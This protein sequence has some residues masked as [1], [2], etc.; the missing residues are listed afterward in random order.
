MENKGCV[1][2]YHGNG[3]GKTTAAIGLC[4]RAAGA[5]LKVLIYQF[6]K[7]N[8]S[9]ERSVLKNIPGIT[10]VDGI[11]KAKFTFNMSS[12]EKQE[13]GAYCR[14]MFCSLVQT[15]VQGNYDV[16]LLD[17]VLHVLRKDM[18]SEEMLLDFLNERPD[19]MEVIL[20]G[21]NPSKKLVDCADYV[22]HI[23]KEKHPFDKKLGA[24]VGIE[25]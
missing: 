8:T 2:I 23:V 18:I 7:D 13:T 1:H 21:Y 11:D 25:K 15:A 14:S 17:E 9:S 4:V 3:K 16:L 20:T 5:G 19:G 22:S 6:L 24:R 12:E 10:L